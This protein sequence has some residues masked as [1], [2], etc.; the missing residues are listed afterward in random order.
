MPEEE[1]AT[2]TPVI[3]PARFNVKLAAKAVCRGNEALKGVTWQVNGLRTDRA[4][5]KVAGNVRGRVVMK[6]IRIEGVDS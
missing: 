4:V 2:D 1:R 6:G 3:S 5:N